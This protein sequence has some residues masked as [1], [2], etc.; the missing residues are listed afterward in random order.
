MYLSYF[1]IVLTTSFLIIF[2]FNNTSDLSN[3][4]VINDG[5]MGGLSQGKLTLNSDGNVIFSGTVSL[6]NNGGFSLVRYRFPSK[7]VKGYT[8]ALITLKGDGKK[9]Q[10]RVKSKAQDPHSYISHFVTSGDWQTI[11]ISLPDMYPAFRGRQLNMQKYPCLNMQEIA[12]L[13]GNKKQ[14]NF[15]LEIDKIILK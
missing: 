6:E 15:R 10:F 9:Y 7:S 5:V 12:F 11:E 8:K 3:W 2:D 13:I 4:N 14:E 1:F